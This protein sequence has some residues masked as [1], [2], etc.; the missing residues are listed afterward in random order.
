[1]PLSVK[2]SKLCQTPL[3]LGMYVPMDHGPPD[4]Q[5]AG[6]LLG[7]VE[8]D[9]VNGGC[10]DLSTSEDDTGA[11]RH[12]T[13]G[14]THVSQDEVGPDVRTTF[15]NHPGFLQACERDGLYVLRGWYVHS[16]LPDE[17]MIV[18]ESQ[19]LFCI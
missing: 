9:I 18:G 7:A 8:G 3:K 19:A 15:Q 4:S 1:M 14:Q 13:Q 2:N 6:D 12:S 5:P 17:K 16:Q 11:H 10:N